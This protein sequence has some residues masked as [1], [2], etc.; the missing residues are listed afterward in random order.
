LLGTSR[1]VTAG[2]L[3]LGIVAIVY[4]LGITNWMRQ[5][6][7]LC[8][9]TPCVVGATVTGA[10]MAILLLVGCTVTGAVIAIFAVPATL[11]DRLLPK[12]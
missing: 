4:W 5:A 9:S 6:L 1:K 10:V 3:G 12:M 8:M 2:F 11:S 7:A